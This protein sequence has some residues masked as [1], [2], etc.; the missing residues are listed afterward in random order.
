MPYEVRVQLA[1]PCIIKA[2]VEPDPCKFCA[3]ELD[4]AVVQLREREPRACG[5]EGDQLLLRGEERTVE[6]RLC[7]GEGAGGWE[8]T[9][10]EEC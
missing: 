1:Q 6:V 2:E 4:G 9:G 10:W 5:A 7:G 3:E 8:G